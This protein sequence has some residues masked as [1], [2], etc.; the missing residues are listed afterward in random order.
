MRLYPAIDIIDGKCV[1]L[2][3]GDYSKKT[4]F[5]ENPIEVAK[6]WQEQG[7]EF[8]HLVDL[9][10]AK[11]GDM[12]NAEL[13]SQIAKEL[14]IPVE[15][16]TPLFAISRVSGWCAHRIEEYQTS[17][18]IIRPAYKFIANNNNV[19]VPLSER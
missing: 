18:K 15:M 19:Y 5:A 17:K 6:M 8:L 14:D 7:G 16:Y 13:I 10:G 11:S 12:P 9:D 2:S 4:T 1:R 3:Q